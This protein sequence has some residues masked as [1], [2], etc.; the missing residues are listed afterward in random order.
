MSYLNNEGTYQVELDALKDMVVPNSQAEQLLSLA[1]RA[2]NRY[3]SYHEDFWSYY[4]E[5]H[6]HFRIDEG[7]MELFR[8]VDFNSDSDYEAMM[9]GVINNLWQRAMY[10][11]L[12]DKNYVN[13]IE[14]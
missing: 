8:S 7:D 6:N 11:K 1:T 2:Y 13:S 3:F 10:G 9:N 5:W 12:G 4:C 14:V